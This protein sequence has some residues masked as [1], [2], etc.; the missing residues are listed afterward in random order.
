VYSGRSLRAILRNF[1][2]SSAEWKNEPNYTGFCVGKKFQDPEQTL[3]TTSMSFYHTTQR[4]ISWTWRRYHNIRFCFAKFLGSFCSSAVYVW[5]IN[6]CRFHEMKQATHSVYTHVLQQN[7]CMIWKSRLCSI[8]L[9]NQAD[10]Y[11]YSSSLSLFSQSLF[12][13]H[14]VFHYFFF[15]LDQH[16]LVIN[17]LIY[18][19]SRA[20]DCI[21]YLP[22]ESFGI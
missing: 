1:L 10:V 4:H 5:R 19:S 15:A 22:S 17:L 12:T 6:I 14:R 13:P 21:R 11:L 8:L 3:S 9:C 7:A 20:F 2:S 16:S 18:S